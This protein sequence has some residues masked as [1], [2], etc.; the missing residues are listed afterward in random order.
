MQVQDTSSKVSRSAWLGLLEHFYARTGLPLPRIHPLKAETLSEPFRK[1]LAHPSDMTP[2]LENFYHEKLAIAVARSERSGNTY[3]REVVLKLASQPHPVAYGVIRIHL[4]ELPPSARN[5][6][7]AERRP[8]GNILEIERVPHTSA[9]QAFFRAEA[10]SHIR[11]FLELEKATD[12]Y[13]RYNILRS[14]PGSPLAEV[15]EFLA[16]IPHAHS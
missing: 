9:P 7:L 13:G 3:L 2:V 16:P 11:A 14:G 12:L 6:V 8:F 1:L 10:D 5:L 4:D 15:I